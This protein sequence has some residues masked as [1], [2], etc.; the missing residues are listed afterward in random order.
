MNRPTIAAIL[1]LLFTFSALAHDGRFPV[2][3]PTEMREDF[4]LLKRGLTELHPGIYR[5]N[6]RE[7]LT[8]KFDDLAAKLDAP[9]SQDRFF[10]LVSQFLSQLRCGHTYVNPYNQK[11][12]LLER[13]TGGRKYIPFYFEFVDGEFIVTANASDADLPIG[14]AI[15]SINGFGTDEIVDSLMSVTTADGEG[16][17]STRFDSLGI[18]R[19]SGPSYS[20]FDIYF[21]LFFPFKDGQFVIE[22]TN[23]RSM[24]EVS[25][26][27][28]AMTKEE[29]TE[30]MEKRYGKNPGYDDGW[31]LSFPDVGTGYLKIDNFITWKLSFDYKVFLAE[32]FADL[33]VKGA[34]NLII[35]IRNS[36]GG[37]S[38]IT[39]ELLR[40]LK[41]EPFA[42]NVPVKTY[43]RTAKAD[44]ELLKYAGG[45]GDEILAALRDGV[46]KE[47]YREAGNGLLEFLG[48][49]GDCAPVKPYPD[50]FSGR[51]FLLVGPA[52]Q[53][54]AFSMAFRFKQEKAAIL[55]GRPTGGNLN[56]FNGGAYIFFTLPNSG[57]EFDIPVFAYFPTNP[58]SAEDSGVVPDIRVPLSAADFGDARDRALQKARS[59]IAGDSTGKP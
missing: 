51:V 21:P 18:D 57:I 42:C 35:D 59:L 47:A 40:Y 36:D 32:A 56:G 53:S 45:Y 1:V 30:A 23:F 34:K 54:A 44:P 33:K 10:V 49:S 46:P 24:K 48:D 9:L 29:R 8:G 6:T 38:T 31:N 41:R 12:E 19:E 55:I 52:N 25:L 16:T 39:N 58:S 37:D 50:G 7:E 5:Y 15:H 13:F 17:N 20:L 27:I 3:T 14:S 26:K 2:L 43:I 28:Q 11:K 22:A 4:E